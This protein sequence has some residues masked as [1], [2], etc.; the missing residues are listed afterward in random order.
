[1]T[2]ESI[3]TPSPSGSSSSVYLAHDDLS[4]NFVKITYAKDNY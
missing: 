2:A 1:M 4:G 3:A